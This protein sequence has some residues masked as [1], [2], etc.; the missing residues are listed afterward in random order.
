MEVKYPFTILEAFCLCLTSLDGKILV[1]WD[2]FYIKFYFY[3]L[4][5]LLNYCQHI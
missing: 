1:N 2:Y 3:L 5:R 4:I